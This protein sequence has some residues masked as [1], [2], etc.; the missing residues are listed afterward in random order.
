MAI[1]R[2]APS[3]YAFHREQADRAAA[4]HGHRV[5][6]LDVTVF[7]RHETGWQHVGQERAACS[8]VIDAGSFSRTDVGEWHA[9][10]FGLPACI[11]A[12]QVRIAEQS[13]AAVAV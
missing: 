8:L 1:T 3:R 13:R 2:S 7:R 10:V 11:A 12:V 6:G 9:N 5:A 4:P